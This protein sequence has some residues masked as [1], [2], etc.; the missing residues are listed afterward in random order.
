M[1]SLAGY[2]QRSSTYGATLW[3]FDDD[4]EVFRNILKQT[5]ARGVPVAV[6]FTKLDHFEVMLRS[7]DNAV[8]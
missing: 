2:S 8:A 1:A 3:K 7:C 4:L 5:Y 6:V